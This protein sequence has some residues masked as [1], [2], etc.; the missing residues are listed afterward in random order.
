[1]RK[2]TVLTLALLYVVA[3][4]SV[5]AFAANAPRINGVESQPHMVPI[6]NSNVPMLETGPE[7]GTT[8]KPS[9]ASMQALGYYMSP[10][11]ILE[12][13]DYDLQHNSRMA[14]QVEVGTDGRVH[15]IWTYKAVAADLGL[16][17]AHYRTW[18]TNGGGF[19]SILSLSDDLGKTPGRFC[20]VDVYNNAGMGVWHYTVGADPQT[21]SA[22]DA[23]SGLNLFTAVNPPAGVINCQNI[24]AGT[25]FIPYIWPSAC[26]DVD[27]SGNVVVH[28]IAM[29]GNTGA[30]YAALT[31][32]RGAPGGTTF[33][34]GMYGTCG[35]FIDSTTTTAYDVAAS[36]TTN[37]VVIAYAKARQNN[38][39]ENS[40]MV[41]R[42]STDMGVNWGPI[43]NI[44]NY[45]TGT[46]E[47]AGEDVSVLFDGRNCFHILYLGTI[48]DSIAGTYSD[49]EVKLFHWTS[50]NA[51]CKSLIVNAT[52]HDANCN[53]PAFAYNVT[54]IN[55]TQCARTATNDTLL[56]AVYTRYLGTTA[57]PDCSFKHYPNGEVFVS[58]SSTWGETWGAPINLTNTKTNNCT[59]GNC[60][61]DRYTS[62]SRYAKDTLRIEYLQDLDAGSFVS[63]ESSTAD[64]ANPV[65]FLSYPCVSMSPYQSL[66]ATPSVIKYW[67]TPFF[68][69]R[70]ATATQNITLMNA[71]NQSASWTRAF[72]YTNGSNWLSCQ[73]SGSVGA[74]CTN[75]ASFV[76]TAG[77]IATEGLYKGKVTF[78]YD[79]P[80]QTFDLPIDFYV[81]DTFR[82]PQDIPLRTATSRM[83]VNQTGQVGDDI[84]GSSWTYFSEVDVD[85]ITDGSLILGNAAHNLSWRI[86]QSGQGEPTAS[87]PYGIIYARDT[88]AIDTL[89][90]GNAFYRKAW[91]TGTNRDSTLEFSVEWYAPK[92]VDTDGFYIGKFD[93]YKGRKTPGT[94]VTGLTVAFSTDWDVPDDSLGSDN[95]AHND[96]TR[97]LVYLQGAYSVDKNNGYGGIAAYREDNQPIAGGFTWTNSQHVYLESGYNCDSMW[98]WLTRINSVQ[99]LPVDTVTDQSITMIIAKGLTISQGD[100]FKFDV[101]HVGKRGELNPGGLPAFLAMVDAG[102]KFLCGHISNSSALCSGCVDC[103]D[104]NSDGAV[105]ISDAVFLIQYIF[106]G[107]AA[108]GTCTYAFGKGDA[109]GDC[110]VDI[111]DAVYLIQYIFAGGAAPHCGVGCK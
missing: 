111:S 37:D 7:I 10:G 15:F 93:L 46:K 32:F 13:T 99:S 85:A 16:R 53:T 17:A 40:D 110:T 89:P 55:I 61:D 50:C 65:M 60:A 104:A 30:G 57:D 106:A 81:F 48:Y 33:Q 68:A 66:S 90:S 52:N 69:K 76:L 70:N 27:G 45:P 73:A 91:G 78:S 83:M 64:L 102:K 75:S 25:K 97:N 21:T 87:N 79:S 1:M 44:T 105:D 24:H 35:T 47:R 101:I 14:R 108:P 12:T 9:A 43:V 23:G 56:Y 72:S 96:P 18:V 71:G 77:P 5:A 82:L 39:R 54:K 2:L 51:L 67:P 80:V 84:G 88:I 6:E 4:T 22:M 41:Y 49:Q 94:P 28:I 42:K 20:T 92:F 36:P 31:Y 100:H 38:N 107:G 62:S 11:L 98:N 109:N 58:A 26:T 63:N 95:I 8:S 74:G 3:L 34:D 86:Y 19:G 59:G 29:E 103:G